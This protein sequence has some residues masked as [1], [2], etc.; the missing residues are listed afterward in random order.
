[1]SDGRAAGFGVVVRDAAIVV[2]LSLGLSVAVNA[3]RSTGGIPLVAE[4]EYQ[5]L[6]PCPE[7]EGK[8]E[9][10]QAAAVK[11]SARGVLLV[12]AREVAPGQWRPAGAISIPYDFLEPTSPE[13]LRKVLDSRARRVVVFGDG[14]DPDS[15][16]QLANELAGHGIRNVVF[17]S[18]GAPALRA[19]AG[20]GK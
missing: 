20:A 1:M 8:A 19:A 12:D 10:V 16:Q 6:V 18:G 4:H 3:A 14:A 7:H 15:G 9:Q 17:V 11:L 5:V 2:A 13:I